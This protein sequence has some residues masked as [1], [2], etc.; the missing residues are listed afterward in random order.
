MCTQ[1]R[2]L[3]VMIIDFLFVYQSIQKHM[4]VLEVSCYIR[5]AWF[6]VY[7]VLIWKTQSMGTGSRNM[8][9]VGWKFELKYIDLHSNLHLLMF[10]KTYEVL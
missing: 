3:I 10:C 5:H 4:P 9:R 8:A 1:I 6:Y 7:M 2:T